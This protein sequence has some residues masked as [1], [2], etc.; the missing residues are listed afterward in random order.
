[1][2]GNI[3]A[4]F[5]E[6]SSSIAYRQLSTAAGTAFSVP[7]FVL[8][9]DEADFSG[10]QLRYGE[11]TDF[12]DRPGPDGEMKLGAGGGRNAGTG[13]IPGSSETA[14]LFRRKAT[15]LSGMADAVDQCFSMI[16]RT[17]L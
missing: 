9:V 17:Q 2:H 1:L 4:M 11:W 16:W 12:A 6:N 14:R 13:G 5:I 15:G 10:W 7:E 8:R 3:I